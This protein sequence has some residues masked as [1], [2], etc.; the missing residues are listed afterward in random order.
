MGAWRSSR[1]P[2]RSRCWSASWV[3]SR[4]PATRRSPTRAGPRT[5]P[6]PRSTRTPMPI[7]AGRWRSC[8]TASSRTRA[9]CAPPLPSAATSFAP[10]PIPKS[11]CI[12]WRS[13]TPRAGLWSTPWPAR[14][15]RSRAPTAS[16]SCRAASPRPL[17]LRGAARPCSSRSATARTSWRPTP[18]R[19]SP[20]PG[21]SCTWTR[22]KSPR[23]APATTASWTSPRSRRRRRSR[24]WIGTWRRSSEADSR[25]SCSKRSWSSRRASGTRCAATSSRKR[26]PSGWV[27]STSPTRTCS[28]SNAS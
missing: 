5:A 21:R 20:T 28:R 24:R 17:W 4:R 3:P 8:I 14:C 27:G 19:S 26:A 6:P 9:C 16:R 12:W 10:R 25:T 15:G 13:C 1:R 22:A 11:S 18:R 7:A 2:E 23:C